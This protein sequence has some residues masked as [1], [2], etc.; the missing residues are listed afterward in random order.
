MELID[1]IGDAT[2][3]VISGVERT[4]TRLFGSSNER[5]VRQ[6]GFVR[7]R[8]GATT[9]TPGS[10]LDQINQ[11]EPVME[12]LTDDELKQTT[13][14]LR[15]K[16]NAGQTLDD[17][18]P[19]AFAAVREG[20]KRFMRMRHYDVQMVGGY[21]LHKG[22]IAEMMTGEGKTLVATLP[23]FLN[24]LAG[25]VHVITVNDYLALRDMEW[26]AP[27]Y[28][29]LGLTVG[30]IQSNMREP[31]R[32]KAYACDITY[33]T[34]NEFGF[35]Y[36]RDNMKPRKDLQVQKRRQYAIIDEIDNILI[37][38]ARTP[39][40]I[41]G[42]AHDDVTKYPKAHRIGLQLKRDIH[43]EVKEKEHTCHLTD[44]GI[45]YAEELAGVESFYTA[46]NMEWPHLID[47]SLRA[48]HLYK[49]DVNYIVE[50]DEIIII[51]EHT[52]RKMEGR[53]WSDGLH[54]AVQAKE[55][56]RI[57]E[58]TQTFATVTLQNF[59]KLYP[60]LSGMTG[61]AMTEANEFWKIYKLDVVAVPTN[62]PTQRINHHDAIYRTV[63]EKWD[64]VIE[65]VKEVHATG[66]PVLVGTVSIENSEHLS[67]KL[68]QQ[69]VKHNMLNAKYHEREAEIIAQ[70]GRLGAV[71][72]STNMAGRGTDIILG[73]NPE[74]LAWDELK[75]TYVSRLDVPKSVWNETTKRI[76]VRE[77]MDSE[78]KKVAELGGLH[79]VGTERHDSRRIDLQLRGRAGRQGDPGSS[80]FFLS[81]EDDLM[82]KFGGEWV[83]DWL[84]AMGM[85]E[86][87]RI[88]NG[89]VTSRI[90][91][92]QKKVE[93]RHFE[94]RKHLLEYD[95]VMDEQRK[96][97]Y[98]YRQ[99]ILDGAICRPL[100]LNMIDRQL[101]RWTKT[102][103]SP[104]YRWETAANWAGA[105]FGIQVDASDLRDMDYDRM[106]D[107]LR[108]QAERQAEDQIREQME[109]NLPA[110][111]D[112]RERNWSAMSRWVN[113]HFGINT[114]DRELRKIGIDELQ[115]YLYQ[116]AKDA[117]GRYEFE[118]L[119]EYLSDDWG[120]RSLAG[121]IQHQFGLDIPPQE[122]D[123]LE[124]PA[125]V[126]H[127]RSRILDHYTRKEIT[128]PVSVGMSQFL[129]ETGG[130]STER[131]D[132]SGLVAW[133]NAR[134]HTR[135]SADQFDN[136]SRSSIES[137]LILKSEQFAP[138]AGIL[139]EIQQLV[140]QTCGEVPEDRDLDPN[141]ASAKTTAK[142]P[143]AP[144]R[145]ISPEAAHRLAQWSN[146]RFGS[147]LEADDFEDKDV[148]KARDYLI[149]QFTRRY[150]PEL[151]T[152]ERMLIL[153][154]L[155]GAWK[156]H[157]Y[158]MDHLRS[159]IGLVGYA[160]KDPKV[161]YRRE[162]MRAFEQMW[163]RIGDQVT[164]A[165]FRIE[166]VSPNFVGSLW[167]V[168][169]ETHAAPGSLAD[170]SEDGGSNMV[171][172]RGEGANG[173]PV[174]ETIRNSSQ[175]VGRNDPCPCGS[176]KKFKK[177]CGQ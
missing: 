120:R 139:E 154:C 68:T 127:I 53:Q 20:G 61:T 176:G 159:N 98:G 63:K 162:G 19:E 131:Y 84:T 12:K 70:A 165:I 161:E 60:K 108:D 67:R 138:P 54:Q 175:R 94:S 5:R 35:D 52:G 39:L 144:F 123:G 4:L 66:R 41:S 133:S 97:V 169:S 58:D 17:I 80:R 56:V 146:D 117:I 119:N 50:N 8:Q 140:I 1:K 31:E 75:N 174:V 57:K 152:A 121:W 38:E 10:T 43:F 143:K 24:G 122:F 7:D 11:L 156:D 33:G 27:L 145:P 116:R 110:D 78:G 92:A 163:D 86:G 36:L 37:D 28:T 126:A 148:T 21:I 81:L 91:A 173:S 107:Y 23:A 76:A 172:H 62:R 87:E 93:E 167:S 83:K 96:R 128:F 114:N 105:K 74:Y 64:A 118:Q 158:Y 137:A 102:F 177:C 136:L 2:N 6:I 99:S 82:R 171:A 109:E 65:E 18:L 104:Q 25:S 125:A 164:G 26:M 13:S 3:A 150:R 135:F 142:T 147:E 129:A 42:P 89:M 90:E 48:I 79:V 44:E 29:G 100:I 49:R 132:R 47:N 55:G 88:E 130:Q 115:I 160:Q 85:Q 30:A 166:D 103:L 168:T 15:A 106:V 22:M 72:I 113:N 170:L 59:F 124:P 73:G 69:G 34:N 112:D 155:D 51:D 46:G 32:Q 153:E 149:E 141:K 111:L 101:N 14:R 16:L 77:G 134:F 71:T 157:L 95:E 45:R 9:I 151:H 40:I